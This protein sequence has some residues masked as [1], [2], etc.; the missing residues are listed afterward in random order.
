MY[1]T[2]EGTGNQTDSTTHAGLQ[3]WSLSGGT[4]TLDYVLPRGL[5]GTVGTNL[6]GEDGPYPDVTTIGLRNLIGTVNDDGL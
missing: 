5:I 6:T 3:K 4:E 2:D 1:V